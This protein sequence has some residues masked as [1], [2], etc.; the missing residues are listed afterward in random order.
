MHK[1]GCPRFKLG[2]YMWV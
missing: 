1:N 2:L